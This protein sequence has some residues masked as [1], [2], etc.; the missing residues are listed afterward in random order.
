MIGFS[1]EQRLHDPTIIQEVILQEIGVKE[2]VRAEL[3]PVQAKP[4]EPR[5][6]IVSDSSGN[7]YEKRMSISSA[8]KFK[9]EFDKDHPAGTVGSSKGDKD[10]EAA[11]SRKSRFNSTHTQFPRGE[12]RK[13]S[14]IFTQNIAPIKKRAVI[15]IILESYLWTISISILT[16]Y[17]LFS[18]DLKMLF[19]DPS[20]GQYFDALTYIC[21]GFFAMEVIMQLIADRKNYLWSFYFFL[22]VISTLSMILDLQYFS[23]SS[24]GSKNLGSLNNIFQSGKTAK[25]GSRASRISRVI[26]IVGMFRMSKIF[27]EAE[28][29]KQKKL[30]K[31]DKELKKKRE[32]KEEEVRKI[33]EQLSGIATLK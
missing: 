1:E 2:P 18:D 31:F 7:K 33:K 13:R 14:D 22:D 4:V 12:S 15:N 5:N 27:K 23:E 16:I 30:D 17:T 19:F 9:L 32:E 3:L 28:K 11:E 8:S 25:L 29:V 6:S 10:L 26:R 20:Q 21:I 24:T